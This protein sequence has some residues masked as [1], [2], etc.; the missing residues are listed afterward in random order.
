MQG[1]ILDRRDFL[2][3]S[4]MGMGALGLAGL[5]AARGE[6]SANRGV[7]PLAPRAPHFAPKAKRVLHIFANGGPSHVDSFD[8]KPSLEKYAGKQIPINLRTERRT[9]A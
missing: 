5:L 8:P 1:P 6:L 9:G 3:R 7:S 4:G 2:A